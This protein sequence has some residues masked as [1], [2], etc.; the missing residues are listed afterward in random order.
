VT[1][2]V[3]IDWA[4]GVGDVTMDPSCSSDEEDGKCVE[5]S[6]DGE[7]ANQSVYVTIRKFEGYFKMGVLFINCEKRQVNVTSSGS[8]SLAG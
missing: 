3:R 7:H 4:A 2:A 6:F 1:L 5:Q 8:C